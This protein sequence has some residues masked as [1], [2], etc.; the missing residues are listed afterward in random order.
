MKI[1]SVL[2]VA[3]LALG[4]APCGAAKPA[5]KAPAKVD[6]SHVVAAAPSGGFVLGNPKARVKLVEYGS[7][8]CPHCRAFDQEGVPTLVGKYV[9]SG[10]VSWEF[11]NYVRDAFDLTAS[12]IVRC[13]GSKGFFP[14]LRGIFNEQ[15][16]WEG[17]IQ[18]TP[19]AEIDQAQALPPQRQFIAFAKIAGLQTWAAAH[20][21]PVAKSNLCLTNGKAVGQL[22]QM[23]RD[24][25]TQYPD[26]AGTPTF[27]IDGSLVKDT[28][29][30][31]TL[32][33]K[34]KQA[35]GG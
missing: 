28:Y 3:A 17:R 19:Q 26:F 12:L 8:T 11:R 13:N 29:T 32:E 2:F 7:L 35:L 27:V 1:A 30:W 10:K 16:V 31:D 21:V 20:G 15:P 6:W 22:V 34:L 23:H 14:L 25:M 9:K 33:P 24:A 4:S 18:G 5:A